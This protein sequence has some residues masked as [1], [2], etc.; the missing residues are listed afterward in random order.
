MCHPKK[1]FKFLAYKKTVQNAPS[2]P[3]FR[4]AKKT[5]LVSDQ[6]KLSDGSQSIK[7]YD[8]SSTHLRGGSDITT[9]VT[10]KLGDNCVDNSLFRI[11]KTTPYLTLG[12]NNGGDEP[13]LEL[14][15][16][17]CGDGDRGHKAAVGD[18]CLLY[19]VAVHCNKSINE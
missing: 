17:L 15:L 7:P 14:L 6:R 1:D 16:V 18:D 2:K 10:S 5:F 4:L 12:V 8:V 13:F 19:A 9:Q 3:T 11:R